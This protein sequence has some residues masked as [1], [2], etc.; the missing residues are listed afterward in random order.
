[1]TIKA[2]TIK[3]LADV[4]NRLIE[5]GKGDYEVICNSEYAILCQKEA[6]EIDDNKKYIDFGGYC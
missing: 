4:L 2:A 6:Y 5:E 3:E 1:M